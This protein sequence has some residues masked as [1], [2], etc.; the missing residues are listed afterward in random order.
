MNW[1]GHKQIPFVIVYTKTDRLKPPQVQPNIERIQQGFL[2]E[3]SELPQ[4]FITSAI[5]KEGREEIL[6][7]IN[8][9]N[10]EIAEDE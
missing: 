4:Q 7:F 10:Q 9:L 1:L 8:Q 5:K 3:W 6:A 2:E